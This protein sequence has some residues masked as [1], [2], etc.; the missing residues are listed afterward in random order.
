MRDRYLTLGEPRRKSHTGRYVLLLLLA[1]AAASGI[2]WWKHRAARSAQTAATPPLAAAQTPAVAAPASPAPAASVPTPAEILKKNGVRFISITIDGPL[3]RSLVAATGRELGQV[4]AQ[5]VT[6]TLVWWISIPAELRKG[7]KLEVLFEER[8]SEE[9]IVHAIRLTSARAAKSFRAYR[10]KPAGATFARFYQPEGSEVELR[11]K[12]APLDDY[13]QVTS[14]VKDGRRHKGID[15]K[16]PLSSKVKA[17]FDGTISRRNWHFRANGNC[18]E[19]T[20]A[21][22]AHRKALFL[23][24]SELPRTA[25]VGIRVTKGE[26]I[27]ASGNSGHSFAPHLHYQLM[28]GERVMDPFTTEATYRRSIRAE[29]RAGLDAEIARL[30]GLMTVALAGN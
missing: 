8:S 7:D 27:A 1:G 18:L 10:F 12:D 15:F 9:P 6:R 17:T 20:E 2:W 26:V 24:L 21:G 22:G 14:H 3:E 16:T 11:L 28:N 4:L 19:I 23:H 13:E 25:Q 29:D 30:D 5:V